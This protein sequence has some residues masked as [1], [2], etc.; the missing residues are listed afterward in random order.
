MLKPA[1]TIKEILT[2]YVGKRAAVKLT[3]NEE[4]EGWQKSEQPGSFF[5]TFRQRLL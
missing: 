1:A 2:E 4:V 3:S 5:A